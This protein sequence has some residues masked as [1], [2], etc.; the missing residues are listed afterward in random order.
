M[1]KA[2]IGNFKGPKGDKGDQGIQ[3]PKGDIGATGPQGPKGDKGETGDAGP[4][5]IQGIQ[6][7]AGPTGTVNANTPVDF[8]EASALENIESGESLSTIFGK[9]KKMIESLLIGAG[10]T[11]LGQ[12]L[13]A[14]RALVSDVNGKIGVST[15]TAAE[16]QHLSGLTQNA[17]NQFDAL[18]ANIS[19]LKP[20]A[21]SGSYNDLS[22]K[23]SIPAAVAVKG[24]A[25]AAYRTGNVNITPA[26]IGLGN[27]NNT[28]DAN[29]SVNYANSAG[30]ANAVAWGNISGKPP[31]YTPSSHT[32][33]DRYYT[34]SEVNNLI[35]NEIQVKE[36]SVDNL[37]VSTGT[38]TQEFSIALSGYWA[39]GLV[40]VSIENAS[41][42]GTSSSQCSIYGYG[43]Y[44]QST[45]FVRLRAWADAKI[46]IIIRV[47][48]WKDPR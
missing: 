18:N 10:S 40:Q 13:T 47:L 24:N 45:A 26:N 28:A 5:G 1:G 3:G 16:L 37:I 8:T 19:N 35:W 20:V 15:I 14:A 38:K 44:S 41:A 42:S 43:M 12:N 27:V 23:P 34:E 25:E 29:K 2:F 48:Y 31:A 36:Y 21:R 6:G 11:L 46:K 7:P 4:Q 30:S 22:N 32:H 17:Q 33:D 39:V 9:I